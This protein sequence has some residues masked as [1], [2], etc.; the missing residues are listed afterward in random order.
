MCLTLLAERR[1][2]WRTAKRG[3]GRLTEL[4]LGALGAIRRTDFSRRIESILRRGPGLRPAT[5][6]AFAAVFAAGVLGAGGALA[7]APQVISFEPAV[8]LAP[9][10]AVARQQ[11][12][13]GTGSVASLETGKARMQDVV[14]HPDQVHAAN[15]YA[16]EVRSA[17]IH[18]AAHVSA[19]RAAGT[20]AALSRHQVRTK[21]K[22]QPV[23]AVAVARADSTEDAPMEEE[24][25]ELQRSFMILTSW[26]ESMPVPVLVRL[27]D[28]RTFLATYNPTPAHT[29]WIVFQL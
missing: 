4:A 25:R 1:M 11:A 21:A 20:S 6:R 22:P 23:R 8:A 10:P 5:G 12:S 26:Q 28:G 2:A 18:K 9:E 17:S 24:Q 13:T 7:H 15:V 16:A 19:S 29:G 14:F 3:H 27:P